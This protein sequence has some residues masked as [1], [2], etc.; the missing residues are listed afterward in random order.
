MHPYCIHT[1]QLIYRDLVQVVP[2]CFQFDLVSPC[3][4]L[5][6]YIYILDNRYKRTLRSLHRQDLLQKNIQAYSHNQGLEGK[7]V[8]I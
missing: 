7:Q 2:Y 1:E 4:S 6:V 3:R 8:S 5:Q